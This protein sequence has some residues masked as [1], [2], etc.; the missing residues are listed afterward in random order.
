MKN[1]LKS[2]VIMKGLVVAIL[3]LLAV[4]SGALADS[5]V[6]SNANAQLCYRPGAGYYVVLTQPFG[7]GPAIITVYVGANIVVQGG[8]Y[9]G[10]GI[11]FQRTPVILRNVPG[12]SNAVNFGGPLASTPQIAGVAI[13]PG[14]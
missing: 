5:V 6:D 7:S 3:G 11:S 1:H 12:D 4:A 2:A 13:L 14:R 8:A 9:T 10:P